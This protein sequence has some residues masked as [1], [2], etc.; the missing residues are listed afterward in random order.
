M[1]LLLL[2][3]ATCWADGNEIRLLPLDDRPCNLLFPEQIARIAGGRVVTPPRKLLG[4]YLM[5]GDRE[6][7]ALWLADSPGP[8]L[9]CSDMLCYGGLVASREAATSRVEA[10]ERL[11]LLRRL[12]EPPVVLATL[13]RLSLRTSDR[14]APYEERLKAWA[15]RGLDAYPEGVPTD[16]VEE[17]LA[18]RRR[19]LEILLR[20]VELVE[21][22]RVARLVI[23]Q[24]DSAATGVHLQERYRLLERIAE[25]RVQNRVTV[26]TGIDELTM[27]LVV[28]ILRGTR[29]GPT[30]KVHYSEP[31]GAG[32]VAPLET[33]TLETMIR[34]HV[35]L[36]GGR[37]THEDAADYHLVV[38]VP[39][40]HARNPADQ[41]LPLVKRLLDEGRRV[42]LAD[43]SQ[44]N[45]M[46][47]QLGERLSAELPFWQLEGLAGWNTAANALGTVVAQAGARQLARAE[48]GRWSE[49]QLLESE[50]THQA[51]LL[52]RLLDDWIY[53]ALLRAE[54]RRQEPPAPR[55]DL[56]N[57]LLNVLGPSELWVRLS[58]VRQGRELFQ[59]RLRGRPLKLL[60]GSRASAERLHLEVVLP[61]PR[62]FEAEVRLDLRLEPGYRRRAREL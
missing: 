12:P 32:K 60:N 35:H 34:D 7:L 16:V 41:V 25:L 56:A 52:A 54:V 49:A 33:D 50:K 58:L 18:V 5:P 55:S 19:N 21:A 1:L 38:T 53:Q 43:L 8:F 40:P 36:L 29:A 42:C 15:T 57:E 3:L 47:P 31:E 59:Q 10:L 6:A 46:Q 17:Y 45:R 30:F 2:T 39:E 9:I 4:N 23:G 11:E 27:E 26:L 14:Q 13:P 48:V 37:L 62:T 24:D 44:V 61:W 22:G 20:L 28:D 51:F